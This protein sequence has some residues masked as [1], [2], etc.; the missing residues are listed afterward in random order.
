VAETLTQLF[1]FLGK[2]VF[3]I[4][5]SL[6]YLIFCLTVYFLAVGRSI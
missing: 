6:C 5:N 2:D 3:N 4:A 1:M